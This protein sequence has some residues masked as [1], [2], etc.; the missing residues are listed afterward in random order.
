MSISSQNIYQTI[1]CRETEWELGILVSGIQFTTIW[2]V[3]AYFRAYDGRHIPS[4][5]LI[6]TWGFNAP[7]KVWGS[8][9]FTQINDD[10]WFKLRNSMRDL[11]ILHDTAQIL[12][13]FKE[14]YKKQFPIHA[15]VFWEDLWAIYWSSPYSN[16]WGSSLGALQLEGYIHIVVEYLLENMPFRQGYIIG[17]P[18]SISQP[19]LKYQNRTIWQ[20]MVWTRSSLYGVYREIFWY[21]YPLGEIFTGEWGTEQD[22]IEWRKRIVQWQSEGN[23]QT[24]VLGGLIEILE[25]SAWFI[26]IKILSSQK[27]FRMNSDWTYEEISK[28]Y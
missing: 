14:N 7:E 15:W 18:D 13:R 4:W 5:T 2:R 20:V 6:G 16:Y 24:A 25:K 3:D 27:I 21:D 10:L 9:L 19:W 12:A 28:F 17:I 26:T 1:R 22:A 11:N 23:L 8:P